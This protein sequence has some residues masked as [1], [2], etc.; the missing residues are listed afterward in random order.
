MNV[1]VRS[2]DDKRMLLANINTSK[3]GIRTNL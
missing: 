1:K 3:D 2:T